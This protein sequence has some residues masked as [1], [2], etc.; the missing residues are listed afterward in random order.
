MIKETLM[1]KRLSCKRVLLLLTV[2]LA[3]ATAGVCAPVTKP[4]STAEDGTVTPAIDPAKLASDA[5]QSAAAEHNLQ[6]SKKNLQRLALAMHNY[7]N[8][9][10]SNLPDDI[11]DKAGKPLLSWRVRLLRY[12]EEEGGALAPPGAARRAPHE[13][14]YKQFKLNEAW[15]SKHN[16]ALLAKMPKVFASPRVTVK[17]KGYTVYQVF[18][19][20]DAVF[21][22]GKTNYKIASITDGT[23]NTLYAVETSKAVPW[24]KPADIPFDKDKAVPDFGKA[25]S[26]RPLGAMMDGSVRVL[27]LKKILPETLK[28]AIMPR[29]GNILGK[30]WEE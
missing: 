2:I 25:Y 8:D 19:G 30:D 5:R 9:N 12:L 1:A 23:S 4:R 13:A 16:L 15:D 29:D 3:A 6:V 10:G 21:N 26:G 14:L 27:D 20:L 17:G 7:V 18:S 11:L 22:A 24:T 28:N